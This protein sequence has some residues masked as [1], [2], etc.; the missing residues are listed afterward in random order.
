M[1]RVG[2]GE[3]LG[4]EYLCV[5]VGGFFVESVVGVVRFVFFRSEERGRLLVFSVVC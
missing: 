1:F 4:E 3:V 2:K 5:L